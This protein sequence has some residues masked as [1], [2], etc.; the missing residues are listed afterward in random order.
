MRTGQ[1]Q[2]NPRHQASSKGLAM[3]LFLLLFLLLIAAA[4]ITGHTV[5]SRDSADWQ[6]STGGWRRVTRM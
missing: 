4:S 6:P 3:E 1:S 5:D 2:Q